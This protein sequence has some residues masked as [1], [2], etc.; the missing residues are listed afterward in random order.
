VDF[1]LDKDQQKKKNRRNQMDKLKF[2][3]PVEWKGKNATIVGVR[4]IGT[5]TVVDLLLV[6][7]VK[8]G[9]DLVQ[10]VIGTA[11]QTEL[12][13]FE[14]DIPAEEIERAED[15]FFSLDAQELDALLKEKYRRD[16]ERLQAEQAKADQAASA[17]LLQDVKIRPSDRVLHTA[18]KLWKDAVRAEQHADE[19]EEIELPSFESKPDLWKPWIEKAKGYISAEDKRAVQIGADP[20]ISGIQ[21]PLQPGSG[22]FG[23][24]SAKE[25]DEA[26]QAKVNGGTAPSDQ[27]KGDESDKSKD[28]TSGQGSGTIN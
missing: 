28:P 22:A 17:T 21:R 5:G 26:E 8:N 27:A 23:V 11:R 9:A 4:T 15:W 2:G 12:V 24:P 6:K 14:H 3:E 20:K 1:T 7:E 13:H 18:E 25:R 16:H 10:N 19:H